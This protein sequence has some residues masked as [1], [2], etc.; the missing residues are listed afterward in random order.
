MKTLSVILS[1]GEKIIINEDQV[2]TVRKEDELTVVRMS[3]SELLQLT[4]PTYEQWENDE[5]IRRD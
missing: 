2:C 4:S 1:S 5:F 3:N